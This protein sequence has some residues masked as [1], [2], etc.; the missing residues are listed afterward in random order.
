MARDTTPFNCEQYRTHPH[1]GMVRYCKGIEN[2]ILRN[3][4]PHQGRPVP[5]DS[6]IAYRSLALQ[7]PSSWSMHA[8]TGK[9]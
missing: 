9:R 2:M 5:S 7:K 8:L 1:P 3:E 4:A 6:I